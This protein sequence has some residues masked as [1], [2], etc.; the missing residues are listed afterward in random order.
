MNKLYIILFVIIYTNAKGQI[1]ENTFNSSGGQ[2]SN[3]SFL[4]DFSIG[5]PLIH[6][7]TSNIQ[8]TEGV[9]QPY[10]EALTKT[11]N[12]IFRL[13][14]F[15]NPAQNELFVTQNFPIDFLLQILDIYGRT[16]PVKVID[17][18]LVDISNLPP[19][20]YLLDIID[21]NSKKVFKSKFIKI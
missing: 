17:E 4:I 5:E 2:S 1:S 6:E 10:F 18:H 21:K 8:V 11:E 14:I 7:Y 20:I 16:Y 19:G 12:E 13:V 15:P 3:T 9:L